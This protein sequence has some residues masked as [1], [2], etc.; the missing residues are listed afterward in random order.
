LLPK[1]ISLYNYQRICLNKG[2]Q[3]RKLIQRIQILKIVLY[4]YVVISLGSIKLLGTE[5]IFVLRMR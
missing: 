2:E 3:T 5:R 1:D 4:I